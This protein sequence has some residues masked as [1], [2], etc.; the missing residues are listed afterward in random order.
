MVL[1]QGSFDLRRFQNGLLATS[2]SIFNEGHMCVSCC[3]HSYF[4]NLIMISST[5]ASI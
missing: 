3:Y 1:S 4:L 2:P 5:N